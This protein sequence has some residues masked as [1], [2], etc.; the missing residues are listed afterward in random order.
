MEAQPVR[1]GEHS[2]LDGDGIQ[3]V[4]SFDAKLPGM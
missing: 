3:L 2:L 4:S 1:F